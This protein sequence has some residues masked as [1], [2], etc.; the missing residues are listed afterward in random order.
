MKLKKVAFV[1]WKKKER[2]TSEVD[3]TE[4][5]SNAAEPLIRFF[6]FG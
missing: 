5:F 1:K 3:E 2:K 6:L 4:G